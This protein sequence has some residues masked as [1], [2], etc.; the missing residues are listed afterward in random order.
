[1]LFLASID[2]NKLHSL[3]DDFNRIKISEQEDF[4][5]YAT[6][7]KQ[8][9]LFKALSKVCNSVDDCKALNIQVFS[10]SVLSAFSGALKY[11]HRQNK[12]LPNSYYILELIK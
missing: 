10:G 6:T 1:M 2:I 11:D 3:I 4:G 12:L 8:I 5:V 9:Q 7:E